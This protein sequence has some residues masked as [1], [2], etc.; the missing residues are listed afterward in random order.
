[1]ADFVFNENTFTASYVTKPGAGGYASILTFSHPRGGRVGVD[2]AFL[3]QSATVNFGRSV[4]KMFFIN[5]N[6]VAYTLGR[7]SG[8]LSL[9]G[10]LGDSEDFGELFGSDVTDPCNGLFTV[11]LDAFGMQPCNEDRPKGKLYMT[12]VVPQSFAITAQTVDGTGAL[13]YTANASFELAN[14]AIERQ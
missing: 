1:M 5:V 3:C 4:Q 10:L 13:W 12:G 9:T 11:Q 6:G 8:T 2:R 14:L 7:G